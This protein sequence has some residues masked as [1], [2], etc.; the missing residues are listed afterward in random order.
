MYS[1]LDGINK[2]LSVFLNISIAID[3]SHDGL[4]EGFKDI[5]LFRSYLNNRQY[6][7]NVKECISDQ[8][9]TNFGVP[10][11][12]VLGPQPSNIYLNDLFL[13]KQKLKSLNLP[14]IV[15]NSTK[16]AVINN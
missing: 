2:A 10:Q 14:S 15:L 5:D 7:T 3:I 11:G 16:A 9:K 6:S 4:L 1:T 12:T 13:S 8:M